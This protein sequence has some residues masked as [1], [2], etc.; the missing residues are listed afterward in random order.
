MNEL[1]IKEEINIMLTLEGRTC[2]FA[3]ATGGDGIMSARELCKYGMNVIMLTH[4][5]AQAQ[6]LMNEINE[7]NYKGK[8]LI[9]QDGKC[10]TPPK[11]DE[12]IFKDIYNTFGS[13]DVIICNTGDDGVEDSIDSVDTQTLLKSIDHLVGGS[14]T[15][16]KSGLP[17]LRKS[18]AARVIFMTTVEGVKGG[19]LESFSNAVAKGAVASLTKNCAA[20]LAGEGINVNCIV[21]GPIERI[22]PEGI[23]DKDLP[24]IKDTTKFL[25]NVPAGRMGTAEDLAQAICYLAS[26]EIGFTTGTFLD[27]SGGMNLL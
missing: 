12:E 5:M 26:E 11:S 22:K 27:L 24:P 15:L 16:L 14:Y 2:V 10:Q 21:K 13:I 1:R 20:R 3:G 7:M 9:V 8:C 6:A 23:R 4:Q 19:I 17:Y 18:R 25:T